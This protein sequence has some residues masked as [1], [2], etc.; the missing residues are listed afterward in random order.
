M[1]PQACGCMRVINP[2]LSTGTGKTMLAKAVA[3]HTT[4]A[5][6]RV[7]GSEFVQKY[8]GE[9]PRMVRPGGAR[10]L[11]SPF[12]RSYPPTRTGPNARRLGFVAGCVIFWLV[13]L[14]DLLVK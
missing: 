6:I 3:H 10:E 13:R 7:V 2:L 4:A 5:F 11:P 14:N 8:L 9:G 1:G 12:S